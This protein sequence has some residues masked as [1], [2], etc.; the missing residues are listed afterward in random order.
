MRNDVICGQYE[1]N[2]VKL[3][4]VLKIIHN[5]FRIFVS[6][7]HYDLSLKGSVY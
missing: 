4:E 6:F 7:A 2:G 3:L 1:H 5:S